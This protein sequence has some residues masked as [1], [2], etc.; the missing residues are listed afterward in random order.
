MKDR[1]DKR[2]VFSATTSQYQMWQDSLQQ[3]MYKNM[4]D[5]IR[6]VMDMVCECIRAN[7]TM[8]VLIIPYP[9]D[10]DDNIDLSKLS[11]FDSVEK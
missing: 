6:S 7:D 9:I 11:Q 3:T 5:F 1:L 4:S 10:G 8:E 2:V